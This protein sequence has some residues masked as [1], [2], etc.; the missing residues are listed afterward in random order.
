MDVKWFLRT[1]RRYTVGDHVYLHSFLPA[2]LDE[3]VWAVLY[4]GRFI[5]VERDSSTHSKENLG[6]SQG[7]AGC[8]GAKSL[9]PVWSPTPDHPHRGLLTIRTDLS[10]GPRRIEPCI[11][12]G[13]PVNR[14]IWQRCFSIFSVSGKEN[15]AA[16]WCGRE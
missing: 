14:A 12:Q 7:Q 16:R 3:G 1:Q 13:P 6:E 11:I 9:L 2:T 10:R 4:S 15:D 5:P 8:C